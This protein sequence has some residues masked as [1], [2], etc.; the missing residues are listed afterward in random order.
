MR[1]GDFLRNL[2]ESLESDKERKIT[3]E[4][5]VL[6]GFR[7]VIDAE[8]L[9]LWPDN[10]LAPV[11]EYKSKN[12]DT[13]MEQLNK[14]GVIVVAKEYC[15]EEIER[16]EISPDLW[17]RQKGRFKG[18][19][20]RCLDDLIDYDSGELEWGDLGPKRYLEAVSAG[21]YLLDG[22]GEHQLLEQFGEQLPGMAEYVEKVYNAY[23]RMR[24]SPENI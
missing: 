9:I 23:K 22:P 2:E 11:I 16:F 3:L 13:R 21:I 6:E 17:P 14:N 4:G 8:G 12:G 18:C 1:K 10:G 24:P 15:E 20:K 7:E 5:D 19:I